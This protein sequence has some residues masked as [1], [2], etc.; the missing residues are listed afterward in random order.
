MIEATLLIEQGEVLPEALRVGRQSEARL[1][2]WLGR[3]Q[4][5]DLDLDQGL[6]ELS[7]P[8]ELVKLVQ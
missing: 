7:R 1:V 6:F 8:I 5:A 4:L 3:K 2:R